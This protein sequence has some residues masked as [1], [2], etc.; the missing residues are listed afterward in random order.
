MSNQT[1]DDIFEARAKSDFI[2]VF[3]KF[4][5]SLEQLFPECHELE[6]A[7][8]V[9]QGMTKGS[10]AR[11]DSL[12]DG[13]YSRAT[14]RPDYKRV[15]YAKAI[16]RLTDEPACLYQVCSY[17]DAEALRVMET[18]GA[19]TKSIDL[20]VKYMDT[21]MTSEMQQTFWKY[22]D[23]LNR[24]AYVA[25]KE[26]FPTLPS[27]VT[28]EENIKTRKQ[29]C[30]SEQPVIMKQFMEHFVNLAKLTNSE[31]SASQNVD[32]ADI[33]SKMNQWNTVCNSFATDN[34]TIGSLCSSRDESA[35][36]LFEAS[37]PQLKLTKSQD[38]EGV[39]QQIDQ[40]N[41]LSSVDK[42][43]P[44]KMMNRIEQMATKLADDL[45]SGNKCLSDLDLTNI[46]QQVV[47]GC[48]PADMNAFAD[49][50][51]HLLPAL[52]NLQAGLHQAK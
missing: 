12:I 14:T 27:R 48:S 39:W 36:L 34:K 30:T 10:A 44:D 50:V 49:N 18:D 17:H 6:D 16:E 20:Y 4:L 45:V 40:M 41:A 46:G 38:L 15:K 13:W 35:L 31:I 28:I 11:E 3:E 42:Q 37:F 5:G 33:K 51:Q 22:I 52:E 43:I 7:I 1:M 2:L 29:T 8:S 9:F 23:E 19:M 21:R 26:K 32:S 47:A 25:K 24:L